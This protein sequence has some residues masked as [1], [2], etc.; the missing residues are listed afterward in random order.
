MADHVDVLK[1]ITKSPHVKYP[2]LTPN[3]RGYQAAVSKNVYYLCHDILFLELL[4][5]VCHLFKCL[6]PF[7]YNI[8]PDLKLVFLC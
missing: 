1:G 6:S 4:T 8:C 2:V 7:I 3:L 5:T